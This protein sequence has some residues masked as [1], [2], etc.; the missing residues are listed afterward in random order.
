MIG[1]LI[2][3]AENELGYH[4]K[5][6]NSQLDSKTA[7]AGANN[8]TKYGAWYDGGSLQGQPWCAIFISWCANQAGIPAD[9]FYP[10]SYCPYG[11]TWY[12]DKGLWHPRSGYVPK[13]GDIIYFSNNGSLA[14]H[15]GLVYAA[16]NTRVYTIEGNTN[17][18]SALVPNGVCVAKKNYSLGYSGILGY[19]S[20]NY[21][22]DDNMTD[23]QAL[24]LAYAAIEQS[25]PFIKNLEDCPAGI[26][27][28]VKELIDKGYIKGTTGSTNYQIGKRKSA[29]EAMVVAYRMLKDVK[30]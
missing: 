8:F 4:E 28:E 9:I 22:E 10:H 11:V 12:K 15:V 26:K 25:D 16:D 20:P 21:K 30:G 1:K 3:T 13:R 18:G 17:D 6:T 5:A 27:S 23:E 29:L 24:K 7:N 19:A 2:A 14:S